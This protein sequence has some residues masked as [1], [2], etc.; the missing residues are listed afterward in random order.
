[1][2]TQFST[3]I[4][5]A[6]QA[7]TK[8]ERRKWSHIVIAA[9]ALG[10]F[11][12]LTLLI[13][14]FEGQLSGNR[15]LL[16]GLATLLIS[17][18]SAGGL[19][20]VLRRQEALI[21]THPLIQK[22]ASA[23][24]H[25]ERI[26]AISPTRQ[27][28]LD[29]F[30]IEVQ[31]LIH[32]DYMEMALYDDKTNAYAIPQ[33]D[34]T[35]PARRA[36]VKWLQN[37]PEREPIL[38]PVAE[39]PPDALKTQDEMI[40]RGVHAIIPLGKQGW[41]G[42][43]P[44]EGAETLSPLQEVTLHRL[45]GPLPAGLERTTVVESQ[46]KRAK[47]L[48]ALYWIA[49]AV[50]FSMPSDDIMELIYTQLSRV[51]PLPNFYVALMQPEKEM[52]T[53]TF[54][55]EGDERLNPAHE[56]SLD[57]G[58][59]GLIIRNGMTI[60]TDDYLAECQKRDIKP[61]GPRPGR[62]WMGA[63]LTAGDKNVGVMVTSSYDIDV[64]FSAEDENFF[65]TVAA[66]TASIIERRNLYERLE[67]RAR[68]LSMLNEIGNLL[69][70]SLDLN[71][72]L[73]LVVRN[74]AALLD[75]EAGS[76]LL[77]DEDSGDL[78][79]RI[80]SGP[81]GDELV[82]LKIPSGKGIAGAT[83][84]NNEPIIVNDT[85]KD[86]RWYGNFDDSSE[87]VTRSIIA[88]PLNARGRT[89]GVLEVI[90]HQDDAPYDK[91]DE[92]LLLAFGAQAA[93]AIENANLFTM[94]DQALQK[95]IEE[96]TM[97]QLIDR[98][99]N[100]TLDYHEVMQQTLEWGLR[101]TEAATGLIA[102]LQEEEDGTR[103]LRFLAHKGFPEELFRRHAEEEL[104]PLSQGFIG[105]TMRNGETQ[106]INDVTQA[107]DITPI[108]PDVRSLMT[109]PIKREN[110]V[111]GL[112][113][114][115]SPETESFTPEHVESVGRLVDH[116]A[117]AIENA[118]LFQQVQLAN[119]AKTEFVSFVSHELKQPMTSMKGYVDLMFKGIGGEVNEQQK[120]FL[121]V[122][123]SNVERMG[124]IVRDLL[125]VSRIESGRLKLEMGQVVP[126]EIVIE[127]VRAFEK[128]IEAKNQELNVDMEPDLGVVW[129][130]KGRLI[131]VLTNLV[132]NANKYTPEGG[133]ITLRVG[134]WSDNGKDYIRWSVVDT[135]IGMT[136]E[137]QD[138]L[139]T[140]YFRSD[141]P[142]VRN[143]KGTGLGLVITRSIVEMHD[144]ELWVESEHGEGSTF[145]FTI[146]IAEP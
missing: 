120:Q 72:V 91:E 57:E 45:A 89:I 113:A 117:I 116:A 43:G 5:D 56:W 69:A 21:K 2:S 100:A 12:L 4:W 9:I 96:L 95:R 59:T 32:P 33:A 70:S 63:P 66:Y 79:F 111:T 26:T 67:S 14:L 44:P 93:I 11:L 51:M 124:R 85:R 50:N 53:F 114:L 76:L 8:T 101:I 99:L 118:R 133:E 145:S 139:F 47:E 125:D 94:T 52:L 38:L 130:D 110:R 17:G 42:I 119:Q 87:F 97:L 64:T 60:R 80:S 108:L 65:M 77:L 54:Y 106:I 62:A 73:D 1:M 13:F 20:L 115:A 128:E 123:R 122:I 37:Q 23:V 3:S 138:R 121:E 81:A 88:A 144:G 31:N 84:A 102:A 132:S 134:R 112:I 22:T 126:E 104:W 74:A 78:I 129:G 35:L 103:G 86:Q 83:F 36:M 71:E 24:S 127:A 105:Q 15:F 27:E 75:S 49:Q 68:Q 48:D 29:A 109:F 7:Q 90:N 46:Q 40:T 141:N 146:P 92:E 18:L 82:G 137:E 58:L 39:L 28:I 41:I 34:L 30:H 142:L 143:V 140:K 55:V 16:I 131:Q 107:S 25:I 61:F 6:I 10:V 98:Q 19:W 136:Q 135:G